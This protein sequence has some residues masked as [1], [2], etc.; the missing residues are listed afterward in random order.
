MCGCV[1][2]S[3]SNWRLLQF[4]FTMPTQVTSS[5]PL[6]TS[7]RAIDTGNRR[8]GG[9]AKGEYDVHES[10][11]E[12]IQAQRRANFWWW[13]WRV[14]APLVVVTLIT[15]LVSPTAYGRFGASGSSTTF[16]VNPRL[17]WWLMEL[18]CSVC[19]AIVFFRSPR[20]GEWVPRLFAGIMLLHYLYRGWIFP[21]L[22]RVHGK[23]TNF[24]L[25]PALGGW[26][27][28]ITHG[29]LNAKWFGEVG[30][31]LNAKWLRSWKFIVGFVLYYSG[32]A[33]TIYHDHIMRTLRDGD[34]PRRVVCVYV[35]VRA[36]VRA[37]LFVA[38]PLLPVCCCRQPTRS[39]APTSDHHQDWCTS[40]ETSR[41][42]V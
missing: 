41:V 15:E 1:L 5:P 37:F 39:I 11:S 27:V 38:H 32:L 42:H 2:L 7:D 21:A 10:K 33:L 25:L 4:C 22:I 35:C 34:G 14:A 16:S 40:I 26:V 18:P 13:V 28:T 17:G 8:N 19:F 30:T 29:W 9:K 6:S 12:K 24:S 20:A 3:N 23:S 36:R 31:H